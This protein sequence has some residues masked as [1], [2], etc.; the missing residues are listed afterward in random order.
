MMEAKNRVRVTTEIQAFRDEEWLRLHEEG[1]TVAAL[2]EEA[3]MSVRHVKRVLSRA[4]KDRDSRMRDT[5]GGPTLSQDVEGD[6]AISAAPRTP[7]WLE[8]VPLFPVGSFTPNSPCPHHGPIREGSLLCCMVCSA[9][10]IDGHPALARDPATDPLPEAKSPRT[11]RSNGL[12]SAVAAIEAETS[13]ETR[14]QRRSR[15]FE[16]GSPAA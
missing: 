11:R 15:I 16:S 5:D 1:R 14:R 6:E 3:G 12:K 10:G 13:L 4:R 8:L 7:W 2:A 9:S